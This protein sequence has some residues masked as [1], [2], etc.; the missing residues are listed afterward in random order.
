MI[1]FLKKGWFEWRTKAR[2]IVFEETKKKNDD[3]FDSAK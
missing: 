1:S 3:Y 2:E